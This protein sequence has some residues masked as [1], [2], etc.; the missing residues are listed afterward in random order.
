M[1]V[2]L[3]GNLPAFWK[4]EIGGEP[5][6]ALAHVVDKDIVHAG[7]TLLA[8]D[9]LRKSHFF[10]NENFPGS[11]PSFRF[12]RLFTCHGS[13]LLS[14][15]FYPVVSKPIPLYHTMGRGAFMAH[16]PSLFPFH[17]PVSASYLSKFD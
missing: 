1:E 7:N 17:P 4:N 11:Y 14:A 10:H 5:D 9:Y 15:C 2:E 3:Q 6:A 13:P 12:N 16:E 8:D